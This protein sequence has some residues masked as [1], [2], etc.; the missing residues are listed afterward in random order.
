[1]KNIIA[2]S[3]LTLFS[4]FPLLAQEGTPGELSA[5]EHK[6]FTIKAD[7]TETKYNVKIMENRRYPMAWNKAD[8]G[9]I[10]QDRKTMDAKVTK[11]IAVDN[12]ND[13]SYDQYF[14]LKYRR[15]VADTFE[16]VPTKNGFEVVV[17]GNIRQRF[18][19]EG[20]YF[21]NN[22]DEDFF[23]VIEFREIG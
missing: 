1:M 8:K 12:N 10:D 14:V 18:D 16:V 20:I 13:N 9:R 6:T 22:E 11:M 17:D 15:S 5:T 19:R 3:I 21:I 7:G 2:L 4:T 23:S